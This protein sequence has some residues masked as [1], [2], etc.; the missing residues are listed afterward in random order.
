MII[1][2]ESEYS[3]EESVYDNASHSGSEHNVRTVRAVSQKLSAHLARFKRTGPPRQSKKQMAAEGAAK[4]KGS[5]SEVDEAPKRS[6]KR[7]RDD[8][9]G[10]TVSGHPKY[11]W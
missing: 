3:S 5:K 8:V 10:Q 9:S 6:A 7:K 1:E 11:S 2:S 4:T